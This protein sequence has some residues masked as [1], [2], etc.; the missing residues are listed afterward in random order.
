MKA[1]SN[2]KKYDLI[3]IWFEVSA[4]FPIPPV[5]PLCCQYLQSNMATEVLRVENQQDS[6]DSLSREAENL[7]G[8]LEEE[9]AK[10]NDVDCKCNI[11]RL[12]LMVFNQWV[13]HS[14]T[15]YSQTQSQ[16]HSQRESLPKPKTSPNYSLFLIIHLFI[17]S[18]PDPKAEMD[19]NHFS[20]SCVCEIVPCKICNL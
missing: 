8:K 11:H 3:L 16:T 18:S 9:R 15:G 17:D 13:S 12:N 10:L 2:K 1:G 14:P 4:P 19:R 7:K 6:I 5:G 20:V